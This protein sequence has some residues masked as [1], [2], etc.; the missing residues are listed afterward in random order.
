[1]STRF[2]AVAFLAA[3]LAVLPAARADEARGVVV[4]LDEPQAHDDDPGREA[5][6]GR[7]YGGSVLLANAA[8]LGLTGACLAWEESFACVAPFLGAGS[9]VHV[10]HGNY[11]RAALSLAAHVALPSLGAILGARATQACD[12]STSH[13]DGGTITT[14]NCGSSTNGLATGAWLGIAAAAVVDAALAY[15]DARV[16]RPEAAARHTPAVLPVMALGRSDAVVG[17]QG[18]F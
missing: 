6:P 12:T 13:L 7:W 1:M 5:A 14:T 8:G 11:G 9:A 15:D 16:P 17:L 2:H 10:A 18:R 4:P 3:H